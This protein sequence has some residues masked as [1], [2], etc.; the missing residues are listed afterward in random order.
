[1]NALAM[2]PPTWNVTVL[3]VAKNEKYVR[4]L[5]ASELRRGNIR[6]NILVLDDIPGCEGVAAAMTA[7]S[8]TRFPAPYDELLLSKAFW[9][10]VP[11]PSFLLQQVDS[12]ICRQD[13]AFL[14][15]LVQYDYAGAP[16]YGVGESDQLYHGGN[17]G[18]SWRSQRAALLALENPNPTGAATLSAANNVN[19][20]PACSGVGP[21][22]RRCNGTLPMR[23][24]EDAFFSTTLHAMVAQRRRDGTGAVVNPAPR[25]VNCRF[26]AET[27]VC[28]PAHR[29]FGLHR[30]WDYLPQAEYDKLAREEC[31]AAPH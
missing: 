9:E 27:L 12:V 11:Y 2:V 18:F 22:G 1:M 8:R 6:I 29:P 16:W 25:N 19:A 28:D 26:A 21:I 10:A 20:S 31:P 30:A 15:E 5:L 7:G 4:K 14:K 13:W 3:C 23:W 17:G 24:H